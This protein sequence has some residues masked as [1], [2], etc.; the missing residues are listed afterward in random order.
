[1]RAG[2]E[3]TRDLRV[4]PRRHSDLRIHSVRA[5]M[6]AAAA[7][8]GRRYYRRR[9]LARGRFRVRQEDVFV[10]GL[11]D[12]LD[13]FSI[14]HVSDLHAGPFLGPG[15]LDDVVTVVNE[16]R[17][18]LVA[19][20]GDYLTD[21]CDEALA[22]VPDLCDLKGRHGRFAVFGNHDYRGRRE[23]EIQA[24]FAA[25]GVRV[26]RD[27]AV[28]VEVRGATLAVVGLEDLEEAKGPVDLEAARSGVRPGDVE[29]VLCHNPAGAQR[30]ARPGCVAVLCGHTHG[31]Q[32]DLPGC[33]LG[34]PHPGPRVEL[35][36]TALITSSGLGVIGVPVRV[37]APAEVV[38]VRLLRPA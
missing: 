1:M 35:G 29:L 9:W 7:L 13:G 21:S 20:T 8:G 37:G 5:V 28:R 17:P 2:N 11:P 27:E 33:R 23:G 16:A 38:W 32:I 34:P 30:L 3:S 18:D 14:A 24:A 31:H 25:R 36:P 15:D 4:P 26:L 6:R 10:P 12:A 22:I 19:L